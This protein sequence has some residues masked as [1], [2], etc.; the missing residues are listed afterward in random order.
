MF[1]RYLRFV[2]AVS[3]DTVGKIGVVL[4]TSSF[5]ILIILEV[6]RLLGFITN[7]YVGLVTYMVFPAL[8]VIGL[9][10]IPLGWR[11]LKKKTGIS[12]KE[13]LEKQLAD[14]DVKGGF[15]GSKIVRTLALL[16]LLNI[17]FFGLMSAR[18]LTFMD[19]PNFCGTA[20][21]TVMNPEWVT[22]QQSPHAR[23][24]CV[25]CHVGEGAQAV[26]DS[27]LNGLWQIISVTFDL[28]EK[29]IPTPVHQLRPARETCE[30]CH[31]PSKHYG[32]RLQT[33]VTHDFDKESTPEFTTLILK[34]D[35]TREPAK[36]GIHWHIADENEVR[37]TSVNDEREEIIWTDVMLPDGSRRRYNNIDLEYEQDADLDIRT[38]DC[39]DCHNR[40]THIYE[41]PERAVDERIRA[42]EISRKLPY[43]KR[44]ALEALTIDYPDTA[45]AIRG[46]ESHLTNFY[47]RN[48]P[49]VLSKQADDLESAIESLRGCYRRN[50]HP[51]MNIT[52]GAYESH[53]GHEGDGGCFRCHNPAMEDDEGNTIDY[54]CTLCHSILAEESE[55]PFDYL[56]PAD[57]TDPA[58]EMHQYLKTE[59]LRSFE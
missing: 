38:M 6:A 11:R 39:V 57:T 47:Q 2:R 18:T 28:Y 29:P 23:V 1:E 54:D 59:F 26:I 30:K 3:T 40:A 24:K 4:T 49:E 42:G 55:E 15:L 41:D 50:I 58:Y 27:K 5:F 21:H 48:Y 35:A 8:F 37:Y 56:A 13:L 16:T 17:A 7:A 34:V 36:A 31:W 12:G 19:Q 43:I 9:L 14:E 22:Y 44:E 51:E 52:W 45:S 20:C 10:I 33:M 53:I 25:E 32:R 46:M